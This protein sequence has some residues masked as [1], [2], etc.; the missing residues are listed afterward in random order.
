[1]SWAVVMEGRTDVTAIVMLIDDR[2]EA[3]TI[4]AEICQRGPLVVVRP[5]PAAD[6]PPAPARVEPQ[7]RR[8]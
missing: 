8:S 6:I 3:E 2:D 4:A 1:M 5:Y 7:D